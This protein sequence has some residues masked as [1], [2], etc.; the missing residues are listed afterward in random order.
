MTDEQVFQ[1]GADGIDAEALVAEIRRTV[2]E[3]AARGAYADADIARAERLNLQ[4]LKDDEFLALY[5]D[6]LR[7]AVY[8]DIG[9]F[10]ILE[11][12][13]RFAPLLVRLKRA[14][15]SLLK[16][17]TYRL[18]SQQNEVNGLLL[19]AVEGIDQRY[20]DRL[21]DLETRVE[22]LEQSAHDKA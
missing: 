12:R 18:W 11:R 13:K 5:L 3:K 17:Y 2:A 1:I 14:I 9:D 10:E 6:C 8:V 19:A 16:F 21:R 20:R 7:E 4:N 22:Q 15:W